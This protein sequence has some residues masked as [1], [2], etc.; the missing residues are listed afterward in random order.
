MAFVQKTLHRVILAVLLMIG[1]APGV[2]AQNDST[3]PGYVMAIHGGAGSIEESNMSA[4]RQQKYR[5]KLEEAI[6]VGY[7]S[8][9]AGSTSV[10]AVIDAIQVMEKSTL[11]NSARGA[12]LTNQ[13]TAELD[14]SIMYGLNR[15]AGA[16]TGVKHAISPIALARLVMNESPHVML[17]FEG[18]DKFA[19]QMGMKTVPNDYFITDKRMRQIERVLEEEEGA[20]GGDGASVPPPAH[21]GTVGAVALDQE[22]NLAAGTSTGGMTNKR[23]GRIGDSPIIGAGT[24]ADNRSAAISSTGWGEYFI[25]GVIAHDIAAMKQYGDLSLK[26]AAR[27]VIMDKLERMGGSGG[28]IALDRDGNVAMPFNTPGMFRATITEDGEVTVKMFGNGK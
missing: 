25:R 26:G 24:Y 1:V 12:V 3:A 14:A 6:R 11:F 27:A 2:Q 22:G 19:E 28:V 8:I 16:V 9:Q 17:G 13:K 18:A 5:A 7:Q 23:W 4:E 15:Q 21:M 10:G 20:S